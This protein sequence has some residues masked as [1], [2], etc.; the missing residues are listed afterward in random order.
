M[1]RKT[2]TST[3]TTTKAFTDR[4]ERFAQ[5]NPIRSGVKAILDDIIQLQ[6]NVLSVTAP[7]MYALTEGAAW[8]NDDHLIALD[9]YRG[10]PQAWAEQL[11]LGAMYLELVKTSAPFTDVLGDVYGSAIAPKQAKAMGQHLTPAGLADGLARFAAQTGQGATTGEANRP[12]N[13]NEGQIVCDPACGTGALLLA[14]L[15]QAF[16][17]HG[18]EGVA[19]M[20]VFANDIDP[21]MVKATVVQIVQSSILHNVPFGGLRVHCS[22][23]IRHY[24]DATADTVAVQICPNRVRSAE[25]ARDETARK[26][27]KAGQATTSTV[28]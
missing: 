16:A 19:R 5:N 8:F 23:L 12:F 20:Y 6:F 4:V 2:T 26:E 18:K 21:A 28:A 1:A 27:A 14:N 15:R 13:A 11:A 7:M 25:H 3:T 24:H 22:D 17:A 10:H 9:E